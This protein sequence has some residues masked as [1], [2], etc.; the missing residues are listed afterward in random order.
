MER[1]VKRG[2]KGERGNQ[3]GVAIWEGKC[4]FFYSNGCVW[5]KGEEGGVIQNKDDS[6]GVDKTQTL[7]FWHCLL[8]GY[9]KR[10]R[11]LSTCF[12]VSL[13]KSFEVLIN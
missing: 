11:L 8:W 2:E 9:N 1:D 6:N 3:R 5:G 12:F 13:R 7:F 10:L 4:G